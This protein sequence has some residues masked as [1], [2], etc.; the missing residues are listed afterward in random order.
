MKTRTN[1]IIIIV[2]L[3]LVLFAGTAFILLQKKNPNDEF[4]KWEEELEKDK[5]ELN[6]LKELKEI[7][8]NYIRN[9]WT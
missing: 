2:S 6:E 8:K 7:R 1:P 3:V 5:K 9:N 4:F